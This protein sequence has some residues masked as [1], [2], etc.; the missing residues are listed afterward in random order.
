[1]SAAG[2]VRSILDV[3]SGNGRWLPLLARKRK[4]AVVALD[5]S[6]DGLRAARQ[7][8]GATNLVGVVRGDAGSL[9]F[10]HQS[11]DLVFCVE[12]FPYV[13]RRGRLKALREL[14]RVTDRWVIVEYRH[15]EGL[16]FAWQRL[17]A[18]LGLE[19]RYPR[20]H[21]SR[22]EVE[23]EIRRAGLGV[24]GIVPVGGLFSRSWIVL[25]EA[26]SPGWLQA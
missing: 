16:R 9:P 8:D 15:R 25:A 18:R 2:K 20:N 11:F 13:A 19:P 22:G 3:G 14:R 10:P 1:M 12:L 24:R 26:P 5:I 6:A 17:R 4:A 21:L 23:N 7:V